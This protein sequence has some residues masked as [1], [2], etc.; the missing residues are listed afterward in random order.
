[1]D[2]FLLKLLVSDGNYFPMSILD[3]SY[4]HDAYA[5]AFSEF[6]NKI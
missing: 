1:M 3:F 2:I 4:Y 5:I 6:P